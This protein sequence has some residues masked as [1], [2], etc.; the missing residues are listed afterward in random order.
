MVNYLYVKDL[1]AAIIYYTENS[2]NETIYHVGDPENLESFVKMIEKH[3]NISVTK[4]SLPSFAFS[5]TGTMTNKLGNKIRALSNK[6]E[7]ASDRL[8]KDFRYPYGLENGI[9]NTIRYYLKSGKLK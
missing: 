8:K 4:K 3:A 6:V 9:Q 7:Y 5:L 2:S 1:T